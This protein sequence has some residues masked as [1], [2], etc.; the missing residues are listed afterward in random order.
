MPSAL[1]HLRRYEGSVVFRR[2]GRRHLM[3]PPVATQTSCRDVCLLVG[4]TFA[5]G[6][7]MFC[8]GLEPH[9]FDPK[10]GVSAFGL[11]FPNAAAAIEAA[12]LLHL[13]T[14]LA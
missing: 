11:P 8:R 9:R 10:S 7:Q 5:L 12:A 2:Q 14:R 1:P 4:S 13:E 6:D 3:P